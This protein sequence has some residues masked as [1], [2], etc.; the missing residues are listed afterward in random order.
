[1]R[2]I[3]VALSLAGSVAAQTALPAR[4]NAVPA[5][6]APRQAQEG[7]VRD[8]RPDPVPPEQRQKLA[9]ATKKMREE[10]N[11]VYQK[12]QAVRSELDVML[13][14]PELDEKAIRAKAA[15]IGKLEGD[16]AMIRGRHYRELGKI[17]P[18]VPI[19]R[20]Q[21]SAA[22]AA[23]PGTNRAMRLQ[24]VVNGQQPPAVRPSAPQAAPPARQ[25]TTPPQ[26]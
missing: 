7:A 20:V 12:M 4:T 26:P 22:E 23:G 21:R 10:Q 11:A 13:K 16:L 9:E 25:T 15:E 24:S 5:P 1:M 19:E 3:V 17:M 6:A 2:T 14:A 8:R 18:N